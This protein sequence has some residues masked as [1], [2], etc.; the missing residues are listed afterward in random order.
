MSDFLCKCILTSVQLARQ[1]GITKRACSCQPDSSTS[2]ALSPA[3]SSRSEQFIVD[4][5]AA[6]HAAPTSCRVIGRAW[7]AH[8]KDN[9]D[10]LDDCKGPCIGHEPGDYDL[11]HCIFLEFERI[12]QGDEETKVHDAERK[13]PR[14]H[15][16][17]V[18]LVRGAPSQVPLLLDN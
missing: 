16:P 18:I 7:Q 8:Q 6:R 9:L 1:R 17:T 2:D 14:Q 4:K 13:A 10:R 12:D 5:P 3:H 11:T 15:L